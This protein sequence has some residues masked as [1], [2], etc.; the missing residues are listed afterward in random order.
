MNEIN[1]LKRLICAIGEDGEVYSEKL[2]K[3]FGSLSAIAEADT[4]ALTS[5]LSGNKN[6]ALYIRLSNIISARRVTD[7]F[8]FGA[9]HTEDE[10]KEYFCALFM[11]VSVETV[12]IMSFDTAGKVISSDYVGEGTV[13]HS[14][15][16]PRK[17]LETALKR[18]A[19]YAIIAHNHPGGYAEPSREDVDSTEILCELFRTSGIGLKA[20]YTVGGGECRVIKCGDEG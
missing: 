8:V 12:Y 7:R 6:L 18:K 4:D 2:Y 19:R 9:K 11:T 5:A 16:F 20:H 13:N 10:I 17:L 14:N 1:A 3:H 15:V